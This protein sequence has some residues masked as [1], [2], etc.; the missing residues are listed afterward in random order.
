MREDEIAGDQSPA[1]GRTRNAA[2]FMVASM[3]Q[4]TSVDAD[5]PIYFR[6][7]ILIWSARVTKKI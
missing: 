1:D 2:A 6:E 3:L 5:S 4:L 7:A